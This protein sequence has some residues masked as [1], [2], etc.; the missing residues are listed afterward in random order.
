MCK[1]ATR[2]NSCDSLRV[3]SHPPCIGRAVATAAFGGNRIL[4]RGDDLDWFAPSVPDRHIEREVHHHEFESWIAVDLD[5]MGAVV[6][7]LLETSGVGVDG[8][9]QAFLT[10][11]G[12]WSPR[13]TGCSPIASAPTATAAA[14]SSISVA[15]G[16]VLIGQD[17]AGALMPSQAS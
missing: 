10:V 1:T 14:A 15:E 5:A 17:R 6:D 9:D 16:L 8:V 3:P 11:A 7:G 12:R 13:C 4:G 2:N